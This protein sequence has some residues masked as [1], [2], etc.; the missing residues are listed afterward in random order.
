MSFEISMK[1]CPFPPSE[2]KCCRINFK[3]AYTT[4]ET[5]LIQLLK[6]YFS[7]YIVSNRLRQAKLSQ[8]VSSVQRGKPVKSGTFCRL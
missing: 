5:E 7:I 4:Q 3:K 6:Q 1:P 8:E 2:Q